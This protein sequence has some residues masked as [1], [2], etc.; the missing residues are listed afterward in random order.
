MDFSSPS[1]ALLSLDRRRPALPEELLAISKPMFTAYTKL[2]STAADDA[3]LKQEY[4]DG[5]YALLTK[6][7]MRWEALAVG[8]YCGTALLEMQ[9]P[10]TASP[11]AGIN[12]TEASKNAP[13]AT[14]VYMDGPRVPSSTA[15][16][17]ATANLPAGILS[18][19]KKVELSVEQTMQLATALQA[20]TLEH[21]EH[22]EPRIRTLVAKAVGAHASWLVFREN[23]SQNDEHYKL[24]QQQATGLH[25]RVSASIEEHMQQGREVPGK[26]IVPAGQVKTI[27]SAPDNSANP[28]PKSAVLDDTTG[29]RALE[30][31]WQCLACF[32]QPLGGLYFQLFPLLEGKLLEQCQKSAIEHVNRHV[33]AAAL[34]VLEQWVRSA[35]AAEKDDTMHPALVKAVT[36]VLKEGLADNWSQVRMAASVLCR[37]FFLE[38]LSVHPPVNPQAMH[39]VLIPRMCLNRFYLAQGV[40]LYSH[41]T[42][43]QVFQ[44]KGL[45]LVAQ[46]VGPICRYYVKMC[47]A[48]NHVVREGACQAVAE[49]A[50]KLSVHAPEQLQPHVAMLLQALLMC[51]HDESWPV[52][53]PLIG[54]SW[55]D[56]YAFYHL[57]HFLLYSCDFDV[58]CLHFCTQCNAMQCNATNTRFGTRLP[59]PAAYSVKHTPR[60]AA[61]NLTR[62]G[63]VGRNN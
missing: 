20:T 27:K 30:T 52:C 60:N 28:T 47:D 49:L 42:W 56:L 21:L 63:N 5:V 6:T 37:V 19:A 1:R 14:T 62:F 18:S 34:L 35:A 7:E 15:S 44:E 25:K 22:T 31:N 61:K 9:T 29:W 39:A 26:E 46:N 50:T 3:T 51:F 38:Y 55:L 45:Q 36:A 23:A 10:M 16:H 24:L 33:R 4:L 53:Y 17:P 48:N 59:W 40:K 54:C 8:V 41:D 43:R 2:T 12:G 11:A 57:I 32:V 13:A 58:D